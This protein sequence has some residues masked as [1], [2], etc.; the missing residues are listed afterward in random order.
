MTKRLPFQTIS[1]K[2]SK[3]A[4]AY[5]VIYPGR[6]QSVLD[7]WP[8]YRERLTN[9]SWQPRLLEAVLLLE[10]DVLHVDGVDAVDHGLDELHLGVAEPVLVGDVVGNT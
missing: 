10:L 1:R 6:G 2:Q 7:E 3:G 4:L 9:S 8:N 5:R